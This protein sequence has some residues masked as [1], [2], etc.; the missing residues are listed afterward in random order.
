MNTLP[1]PQFH[2]PCLF[3]LIPQ[4][5]RGISYTA[6]LSIRRQ[7]E[8]FIASSVARF[9]THDGVIISKNTGDECAEFPDLH[10]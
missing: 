8:G 5:Y 1:P 10:W 2:N 6:I 7:T 3:Y 4:L 9:V